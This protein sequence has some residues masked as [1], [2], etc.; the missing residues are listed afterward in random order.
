MKNIG[1]IIVTGLVM[2]LTAFGGAQVS[3]QTR[4]SGTVIDGKGEPVAGA[5]VMLQG[6]GSVAA[7]TDLDGRYQINIPASVSKP[8]LRFTCMGY[9]DQTVR[10]EGRT[11]VDFTVEEDTEELEEVVVVGYGYMRKSDLT[12]SVA[13]VKIDDEEAS[14]STTIGQL[15]QGHAAGVQ[16]LNNGG[17]PDGGI[18]IRIRG[19]SSFNGS[20]EP[21]YVVDGVIVNADSSSESLINQGMDNTDSDQAVNGLMG[22]NPQDIASIEILKDASATAIYGSHGANGVVLITTK[23]ASRER[24]VI[25]F[26][27]G[28]DISTVS[29]RADILSFDEYTDFIYD[30]ALLGHSG[31]DT[32]LGQIYDDPVNRQGIKVFPADWQD[33]AFRKALSQRYFFSI[34]GKP[35]TTSYT[36]SLGYSD[37]QGVIKTTG[38]EQ[39]TMRL[40]LDKTVGKRLRFGTKTNLA[41]INSNLTQATGGGRFTSATSLIRSILSFRPY[42]RINFNEDYEDEMGN[43]QSSPLRWIDK[44][45]FINSRQE[46]RITPNLYAEFKIAK[47]L[48][49]RS[50]IGGDYRNSEQQKFKSARINTSTEGSNGASGTYEYF[51]WNWDNMLMFNKKF[52]GGHNLSGTLGSTLNSRFSSTQTIQGWGIDQYMA[53]M[54]SIN[55]APYARLNYAESHSQTE[56][57]FIRGI[58]SYKD[59]YVLTATYRLDGSSKFRDENKWASFPSFA[60]AWRLNQEP[61][62]KVDAISMAKL[63]VGWGRVGNQNIGNMLTLSNYTNSTIPTHDPGNL[64]ESTVVLYPGNL[65]NPGLKWETTEQVNAGL[66]LSLWKGRLTFSA[67]VYYKQTFDLLQQKDIPGSSGFERIYVNEGNIENKG[68]ELAI[69]AVPARTK[70]FE[71][72]VNG[73]ISFN[74]NKIVKISETADTKSIFITPDKQQEVVY[75]YGSTLGSSNYVYYPGNI[76]MEGHPMGLFYGWKVKGVVQEGELGTPLSESGA[77]RAPGYLDYYDLN[78]N[79]Y[80]DDDDRTIIG[81]PNPDFTF[82]FGT[83]LVWKRLSLSANFNGSYGND[84]I[85]INRAVETFTNTTSSN[86]LRDAY[87]KAW[88][89]DNPDTTYPAIGQIV[90][91]DSKKVAS[92]YVEDGSYLRLANVTLSYALPVKKNSKFIKGL[93]LSATAGNVYVWTRYSGWDPDV[94]SYGTNIRKMGCDSGSYP[95]NRS[96]SFDVKFTF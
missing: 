27:A 55:S 38:V 60:F 77:G 56:S 68:L 1:K 49:F 72:S 88:T 30:K 25:R 19:M 33:I 13:S 84:I 28:V 96:Y 3:A 14:R 75:F 24:P 86:V 70:D 91:D 69:D 94:N 61:W 20:S 40:N 39:Y 58:Y 10:V 35:N 37:K 21:L 48:T 8:S 51:Y 50:T 12:G 6:S 15:L 57:F 63:R 32:V 16:V 78:G 82:G 81:D 47:W 18:S 87:Y 31:A 92:W 2:V 23:S 93:S 64:A 34:S 9:K 83:T 65:A 26:N 42:S 85:N 7:T 59:R 22:L 41:Y 29:K 73:N 4:V 53:G 95:N 67:D 11:V 66:D 17:A 45:H 43:L 46:Y 89:P 76:F 5:V 54:A 36:F 71:W 52:K 62:F 80:I 79:G 44:N 90:Q 74:R